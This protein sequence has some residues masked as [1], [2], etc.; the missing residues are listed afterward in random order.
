M[1]CRWLSEQEG[2]PESQMCFPPVKDIIECV[3]QKKPLKL[4]ADYLKR[5]GYRLP[6]EAEWEYA[7]RAG[8]AT[9]RP[10]GYSEELLGQYAWDV[11]NSLT[12]TWPSGQKKPNDFGLFDVH[13]NVAEWCMDRYQA[14]ADVGKG[15]VVEDVE[16][17]EEI[18][19]GDMRILRGAP[20]YPR[21]VP[22]RSA[23]RYMHLPTDQFSTV[24]LRLARTHTR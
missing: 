11:R 4:P 19:S 7:C 16:Q 12:R 9:S 6:T 20:F 13:G 17:Q 18:K 10:H 22:L 2:I 8:A 1:Y 24:G 23:Y 15:K 14:Y 3:T 5:T 21:P